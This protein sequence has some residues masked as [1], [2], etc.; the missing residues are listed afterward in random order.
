MNSFPQI[1]TDRLILRDF[2]E[3]DA[4]AVYEIFSNDQVIEFYDI[5]KFSNLDQAIELVAAHRRGNDAQD[6]KGLRWA[7]CLANAPD[8]IIGSC[9]FHA[10]HK[11]FQSMEIGYELHPDHWNKGYAFEAVSEVLRYCFT[12]H[13]PFRI[14]R[15]TARTDLESHRSIA[16]LK[17]LGFS[18][19]GV[20]RQYGFWKSEFHDVRM[21]SLLRQEWEASNFALPSLNG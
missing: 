2:K 1:N 5:D 8:Q 11:T 15:V 6:G 17:K 13:I 4:Q 7:I 20:L 10:T 19:E 21:F 3:S 12:H 14:N 18:E 9:G 16:L